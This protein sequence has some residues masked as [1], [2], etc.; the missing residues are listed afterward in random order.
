MNETK[1]KR[2]WFSF[3]IRDLLWLT[4]VAALAAC[5]WFSHSAMNPPPIPKPERF[6]VVVNNKG[7]ML[8]FKDSR[9]RSGSL[10]AD[11]NASA[12][13]AAARHGG[14]MVG[15]PPNRAKS[16]GSASNSAST[17]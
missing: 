8:T 15:F 4:V 1:P 6:T 3:S 13:R 14:S 5:L 17:N 10:H 12:G 9:D 16:S 11:A 7:D 2:R